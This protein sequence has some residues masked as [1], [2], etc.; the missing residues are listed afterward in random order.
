MEAAKLNAQ[1][2]FVLLNSRSQS[3]DSWQEVADLG[4]VM[5][6]GN[7]DIFQVQITIFD[8]DLHFENYP[9]YGNLMSVY[10]VVIQKNDRKWH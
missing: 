6:I 10:L 4:I 7:C 3:I 1:F 8:I 9:F 5:A 2:L